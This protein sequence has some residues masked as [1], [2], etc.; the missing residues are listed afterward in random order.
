MK[1]YDWVI[2]GGGAQ[3]IY[4]AALLA[5]KGKKIALIERSNGLGGV[6][7]GKR[8]NDLNL[9]F[10]CHVFNNDKA[11]ITALTLEIMRDEYIP[12]SVKYA[13]I[14]NNH[15]CEGIAV[16]DFSWLDKEAQKAALNQIKDNA[17][18]H[19][20]TQNE[21][22]NLEETLNNRYGSDL[23]QYLSN[24]V[25]K[26]AANNNTHDLD[27]SALLRTPLSRV[28]LMDDDDNIVSN[29]KNSSK[30][31][32][33]ILALPSQN[34]EMKYYQDA[35]KSFVHRTFYPKKNGMRGFCDLAEKYLEKVGVDLF[36]GETVESIKETKNN[37]I[38][39]FLKD[40]DILI[41]EKLIWALDQ[42]ALSKILWGEDAMIN[43][44]AKIPMALF[45]FFMDK[46]D[47]PSY[48]YVHDFTPESWVFR[49][50]SPGFYGQQSNSK[51]QSYI[52]A[53]C[54]TEMSSDL[55][56]SPDKYKNKIWEELNK[57][58]MIVK[59]EWQEAYTLSTPVSY[60]MFKVGYEQ[61]LARIS[62]KLDE[63]YPNVLNLNINAYAKNGLIEAISEKLENI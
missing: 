52:C 54:V 19:K 61:V 34:D 24:I 58:G 26:L 33:A 49:A 53:E 55:W 57:M 1:V 5:K 35:K 44:V 32:D 15:L 37:S 9:D 23:A 59:T 12:L 7:R 14:T 11:D 60:S 62:N 29:L 27:P 40:S 18:I 47:Q 30:E 45:Y 4:A 36:L 41:S 48:T 16:P 17:L 50:S 63:D 43:H 10:G 38:K 42:G 28:H 13:S 20:I 6:L 3:G 46:D 21:A 8:H 25:L 2:V 51:G 31:I 22:F 56:K 39:T